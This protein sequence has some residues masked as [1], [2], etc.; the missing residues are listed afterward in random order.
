MPV[1]TIADPS[2]PRPFIIFRHSKSGDVSD[3]PLIEIA[4]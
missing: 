2:P 3:A 4:G 1:E